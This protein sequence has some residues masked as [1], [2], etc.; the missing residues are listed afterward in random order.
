[1]S[2]SISCMKKA[3]GASNFDGIPSVAAYEQ[4]A[5]GTCWWS[6]SFAGG[7]NQ[8]SFMIFNSGNATG[9]ANDG[10]IL[11]Y[12]PLTNAWFYNQQGK[13]PNYGSGS[14]YHSLM[15]Y[16]A[17]KNVAV[18]GGGNAAP[19]KLWRLS[20]DGSVLAMP[21]VPSGKTVGIQ[22]GV[23]VDEP[24]T[25]NFLLLSAG[26]LWE[27]NPTGSGTWTQRTSPPAGVSVPGATTLAPV[28]SSIPDYGIV[29]FVTQPNQNNGTFYLYKNAASSRIEG[30]GK[31]SRVTEGLSVDISPNP[32]RSSVAISIASNGRGNVSAWIY[33]VQGKCVADLTRDFG[34]GNRVTW[35]SGC[36]PA[37]IYLLH[38]SIGNKRFAEAILLRK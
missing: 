7:G 27:L 23:F 15:E 8:G 1:M 34:Q 24:V 32:F 5:L 6:G 25:G 29:A 17:K 14:T 4:V 2:G 20:S 35:G 9:G 33:N 22:Q 16:S 21:D 10:Q 26:E 30:P 37:G 28:A 38:G 3:Y 13:A 31:D 18:Y 19:N 36:L 11:A 12:N